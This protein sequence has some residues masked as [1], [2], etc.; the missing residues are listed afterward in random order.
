MSRSLS[1]SSDTG[2]ESRCTCECCADADKGHSPG[3][4]RCGEC[5]PC[6]P[7]GLRRPLGSVSGSSGFPAA[8]AWSSSASLLQPWVCSCRT[9][10]PQSVTDMNEFRTDRQTDR[11][12]LTCFS[13]RHFARRFW[14]Q[15][16]TCKTKWARFSNNVF[17][18]CLSDFFLN[19]P[20]NQQTN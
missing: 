2:G 3:E 15:V 4:D 7:R 17:G 20:T 13:L 8:L 14:N 1:E 11:R 10:Q 19:Q 16:L 18:K 5:G 6:A 12:P 9:T